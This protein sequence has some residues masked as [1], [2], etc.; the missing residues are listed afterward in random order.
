MEYYA[1]AQGN[2][3]NC[4]GKKMKLQ[5]HKKGYLYFT[6]WNPDKYG[7]KKKRTRTVSRFVWEHFNGEIPMGYEIDHINGVRTDNRIENLR[8]VTPLENNRSRDIV[9]LDVYTAGLIR[10]LY[11]TGEYTYRRL[12]EMF[13]VHYSVIADII[14]NKIWK[15]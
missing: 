3:Y 11:G 6:E 1:D 4:T 12:G 13:E 5:L 7:D 2:I 15:E 8:C 9:K 14:N 10:A